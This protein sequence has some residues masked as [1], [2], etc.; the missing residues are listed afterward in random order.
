[1][2]TK[3]LYLLGA[4]LSFVTG[5]ASAAD[6]TITISGQVRDNACA[7][8]TESKNFTVDLMTS[9]LK[10]FKSPGATTPAVPFTIMLSPC[11]SLATAIKI[12]FTGVADN[13]NSSLLKLDGGSD[14][15]SGMAIQVLDER[16]V[17]VPLNAPSS[18]LT[19]TSLA[20]GQSNALNFYARLMGTQLPATAGNVQ[21]TATFTLE[22][23]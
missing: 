14:A 23:Q 4:L 10:G 3:S 2:M 21:A 8:G 22:F 7:V 15:A 17:P 6:S 11:G 13:D 9:N 19:W 18:S 16:Q 12:G 1:M 20:P 5:S